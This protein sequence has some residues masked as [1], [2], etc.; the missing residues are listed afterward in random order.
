MSH[1]NPGLLGRCGGCCPE[2]LV[3]G[4]C[5]NVDL[6]KSS[7]KVVISGFSGIRTNVC[8]GFPPYQACTDTFWLDS[9]DIN[10]TYLPTYLG[11]GGATAQPPAGFAQICW[12][13]AAPPVADNYS[14]SPCGSQPG[15]SIAMGARHVYFGILADGRNARFQVLST[16]GFP[17][18]LGEPPS[19][20]YL[21]G[22][23]SPS[24]I[25]SLWQTPLI[26]ISSGG[27]DCL[28]ITTPF[29]WVADPTTV[30]MN[31][32]GALVNWT[33]YYDTPGTVNVTA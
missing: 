10:G 20:G 33:T 12:W 13:C 21:C 19:S 5:N 15:F 2:S 18:G 1:R 30:L 25:L 28:A 9:A 14:R 8:T 24:F 11:C 7:P 4:G 16:F 22:P 29:E 17:S 3:C 26:P 27:I 32:P 31:F 23:V 6:F